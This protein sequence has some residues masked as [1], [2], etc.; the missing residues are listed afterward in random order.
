[1]DVTSRPLYLGRL[2]G[3]IICP[4]LQVINRIW[5]L[6]IDATKV[7]GHDGEV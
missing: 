6:A 5:E 3:M 4:F 1:M 2:I 7:S